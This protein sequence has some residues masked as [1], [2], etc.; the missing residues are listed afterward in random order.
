MENGTLL[1]N[2]YQILKP[3]G[4]GGLGVIYLGY[5]VNLQKYVVIKKVKEHCSSLMNNR[6]EVDILKS[7]HHTYLPQVYDFI[8][9]D[10]GIFTVMDYISGHD[11]KYYID[12]GYRFEEEQLIEWMKQLCEVLSYLHSRKPAIIHCDI[13]PGNIMITEE[14][15]V[16]LIDFNISLDGENNKDLVGLSSMF[17]S[18][19]QIRKA[20]HKMRYGSGDQVKMDERTDLYSLGAVFY[21][22]VS[23]YRPET[24]SGYVPPLHSMERSCS[25]SL[26]NII[27]KAMAMDPAK[28]FKSAEKMLE[29]LK[30]QEQWTSRYKKLWKMGLIL[31][32]SMA[33]TAIVLIALMIV[34]YRGMK[35]DEFYQAYDA[36]MIQVNEWAEEQDGSAASG[37][38]EK[39]AA[40]EIIS[41][42]IAIL[43]QKDFSDH[44]E[45]YA[46]QKAD[47]LYGTAQACLNLEEYSQAK[48][49]LEEALECENTRPEIY[50]DLAIVQANLGRVSQA[51]KSLEEAM[52]HGLDKEEGSLLKSEIAM[53]EGDYESAWNYALQAAG[54][55]DRETAERAAY[56]ILKAG[57]A[58]EN[59]QECITFLSEMAQQSE[60][61]MKA[62][63]IRKQGECCLKAYENG[64]QTYIRQAASCFEALEGSG[65][66]GKED[67][68]NL[69]A[70][71][72][73]QEQ[74]EK[75]ESVLLAMKKDYPEEYKVPMY[76]AFV[77][78]RSQ[79][80]RSGNSRDYGDVVQYYNE[81]VKICKRSGIDPDDDAD[82]LQIEQ[83][84]NQ[85]EEQGW[86][87]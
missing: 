43:N 60:G 9:M 44:L 76:L 49:Y 57:E 61:A 34:G 53:A 52:E 2:T 40:R 68:Y 63:W 45:K 86:L 10:D 42:G 22:L 15:N 31:D 36:Y 66:A 38:E 19:E 8:E 30:H 29:A 7:L 33:C 77:T 69:T 67:L 78:Y 14:G 46:S 71:Y 35:N 17:A 58:L 3:I 55:S 1:N 13:K 48:Q 25:D 83:I 11:L 5:H 16:C 62:M 80:K 4:T 27:D 74:F 84:I 20:E 51:E 56:Y 21:Y 81:A 75:A 70:C 37:A 41:A 65:Y 32:F 28:R 47:I 6:I 87:K 26:T 12:A 64:Q 54:S 79:S 72:I 24:R 23:G 39:Q 18:P 59:T 73:A 82:M 50:R 85:L